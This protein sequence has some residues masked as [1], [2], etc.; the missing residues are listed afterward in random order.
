M[1]KKVKINAGI[2]LGISVYSTFIAVLYLRMRNAENNLEDYD[3]RLCPSSFDCRNIVDATILDYGSSEFS[4]QNYGSKG[5][6][7]ESGTFKKYVFEMLIGNSEENIIVLPNT[8]S[9]T[10][11]FDLENIYIPS[12]SDSSFLKGSLFNGK[13]VFVEV[14]RGD[15]TFILITS[16]TAIQDNGNQ[17]EQT[18]S[19]APSKSFSYETVVPTKLHPVILAEFA[20]ND[21]LG[22]TTFGVFMSL[23]I[24]VPSI[25]WHIM[26]R[27][28]KG[29]EE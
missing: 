15:V 21:F 25:S 1:F 6:P 20:K 14:W 11:K 18:V 23:S 22:W 13:R 10:S 26:V 7:L 29:S 4:F 9:D 24:F 17:N 19:I 16:N 3:D 27:R 8:P 12:K 5:I 28:K 2:L